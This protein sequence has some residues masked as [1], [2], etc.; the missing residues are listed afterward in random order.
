[1]RIPSLSRK[2]LAVTLCLVL[3][4]SVFSQTVAT[5]ASSFSELPFAVTLNREVDLMRSLFAETNTSFDEKVLQSVEK[6]AKRPVV[7]SYQ[8][9]SFIFYYPTGV[10]Y[11]TSS[12]TEMDQP[13]ELVCTMAGVTRKATTNEISANCVRLMDSQRATVGA[14]LDLLL[15]V[16]PLER[17]QD[18][19]YV[20]RT[21]RFVYK[22]GWTEE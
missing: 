22:N 9:I 17:P 1:M 10:V 15:G 12:S 21:F 4:P 18:T 16:A 2:I 11:L 13:D 19:R 20:R 6:D 7:I 8:L 5:N 14:D 3:A